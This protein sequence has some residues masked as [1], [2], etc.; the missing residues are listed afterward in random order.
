[1]DESNIRTGW[2]AV[3]PLLAHVLISQSGSAGKSKYFH[4]ND[5]GKR[6]LEGEKKIY[7]S[8]SGEYYE[9]LT[10]LATNEGL[11]VRVDPTDSFV[12]KIMSDITHH[13][14]G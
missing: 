5:A 7:R 13:G 8:G 12:V 10:E 4:I 2:R 3:E 11:N 9:T 1:M 14:R 6:L